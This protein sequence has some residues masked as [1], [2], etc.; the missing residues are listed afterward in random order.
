MMSSS[1]R[2]RRHFRVI[3]EIDS[4]V[5][6]DGVGVGPGSAGLWERGLHEEKSLVTPGY[7]TTPMTPTQ[8]M[9]ARHLCR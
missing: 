2:C 5:D 4:I 7:V 6:G 9:S 3:A 8:I 1:K